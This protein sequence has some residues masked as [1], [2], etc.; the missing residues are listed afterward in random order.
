M[1]FYRT[2]RARR[3]SVAPRHGALQTGVR[4]PAG[5]C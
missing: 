2:R 3:T 5:V 4:G 1:P